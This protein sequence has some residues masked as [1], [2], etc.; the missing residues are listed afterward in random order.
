MR[1]SQ[2]IDRYMDDLEAALLKSLSAYHEST[3]EEF[4]K[5]D[6]EIVALQ[7]KL[8]GTL[9]SLFGERTLKTIITYYANDSLSQW[10]EQVS[11]V[12]SRIADIQS[13]SVTIS[14][15]NTAINEVLERLDRYILLCYDNYNETVLFARDPSKT[16]SIA[17]SRCAHTKVS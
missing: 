13:R 8:E 15:D 17:S 9:A 6:E 3:V 12:E 10:R 7:E 16:K 5:I 14:T 1:L 2:H 11:K 4:T